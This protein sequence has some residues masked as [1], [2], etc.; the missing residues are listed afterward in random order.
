ML[1]SL[2]GI[3]NASLVTDEPSGHGQDVVAWD[4]QNKLEFPIPFSDMKPEIYLGMNK[5]FDCNKSSLSLSLDPYLPHVC[6]LALS[7]S[8]R[9][10][11]VIQLMNLYLTCLFL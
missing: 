2:G 5:M 7:S 1:G 9:Q 3:V 10:T 4:S 8:D 6:N 11:K